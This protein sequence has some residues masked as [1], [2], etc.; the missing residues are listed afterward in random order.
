MQLGDILESYDDYDVDK[1]LNTVKL[2]QEIVVYLNSNSSV[3]EW[4]HNTI[5]K[6]IF[7]E[8]MSIREL[9]RQSKINFTVLQRSVKNTRERIKEKFGV[10]YQNLKT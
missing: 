7:F 1:D 10:D 3:D 2:Y 4:F 5:F 9:E 8:N 6:Y